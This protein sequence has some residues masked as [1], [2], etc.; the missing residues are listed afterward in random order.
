MRHGDIL[1]RQRNRPERAVAAGVTVATV[2][3]L[4]LH[5]AGDAL[6]IA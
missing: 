5:V 6:T 1:Q 4:G 2:V 3:R